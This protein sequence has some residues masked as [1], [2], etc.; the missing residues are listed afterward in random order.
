LKPKCKQTNKH[1]GKMNLKD[2][3]VYRLP[4]GRELVAYMTCDN[5]TVLFN[6]SD[7]ESR[8]YELNSEGRLLF[9]GQLTA[10]QID[11]LVEAGRVAAAEVT[12]ILAVSSGT[13][14]D[15]TNDQST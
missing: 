4:N 5:E 14:R 8:M 11:D 3:A 10:W 6:L 7:S 15:M 9:D 1:G 13:Q 12:S 2:S